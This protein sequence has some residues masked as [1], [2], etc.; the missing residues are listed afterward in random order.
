MCEK[1][2][3]TDDVVVK[4]VTSESVCESGEKLLPTWPGGGVS[5][6]QNEEMR[7]RG[8]MRTLRKRFMSKH[9][10]KSFLDDSISP[11]R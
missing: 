9:L 1:R 2:Q 4:A 10:Q 6:S 3:R 7:K 5:F 8:K 11:D